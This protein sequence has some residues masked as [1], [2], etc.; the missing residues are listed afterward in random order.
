MNANEERRPS[1]HTRVEVQES[2]PI[3]DWELASREVDASIRGI[4]P[5]N[6][7]LVQSQDNTASGRVALP[8]YSQRN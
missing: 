7:F 4:M 8:Q 1:V 2:V 3:A 5:V 6:V